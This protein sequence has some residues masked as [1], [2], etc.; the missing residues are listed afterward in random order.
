MDSLKKYVV[1]LTAILVML[2]VVVCSC[3]QT[4][5]SDSQSGLPLSS[6]PASGYS[7]SGALQSVPPYSSDSS[8]AVSSSEV[9]PSLS[10]QSSESSTS[11]S[12]GL[13]HYFPPAGGAAAVSSTVSIPSV[14]SPNQSV[15]KPEQSDD[16]PTS[17]APTVPPQEDSQTPNAG[18][19]EDGEMR[20]VWI[21]YIELNFTGLNA[22]Q[23]KQ[24]LQEMFNSVKDMGFNTVIVHARS[25]GDAYYKSSYF[26]Y[27]SYITGTQGADPGWDP[28]EYMVELAH[29]LGLKIQA[30]INPYR[31]SSA[32][33]DPMT[34]A[35]SNKARQWLTDSDP[36][37]DDWAIRCNGGIYFNPA[38][39]EVRRLII[40]GIREIVQNYDVDGVHFDDYFYPTTD[41]GFDAA[42]YSEYASSGG[43]LSLADWRR[44]QVNTLVSGVYQAVKSIDEDIPFGI[45]PAGNISN[46]YNSMYADV[47][48]WMS[49]KGYIDY[50]C[51]QLYWG[52][53]Y[54]NEQ[55]R[56]NNI[57]DTWSS[58]DMHDGLKLYF[59]LAVYKSGTTDAGSDEWIRNNDII[60]RQIE[61]SRTKSNCSGVILFSYSYVVSNV[62][63]CANERENY[64]LLF[65]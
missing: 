56:F 53:E 42:A 15:S 14:P 51:P 22:E 62:E 65:N 46:C 13:P 30:W 9:Q 34:L 36:S 39:P 37:N 31:V 48:L 57:A 17:Q 54:P 12:S 32:S 55:F 29:G 47:E 49:R 11:A 7:S 43:G 61:Y 18:A 2:T 16:A 35:E 27:S 25:H 45:S 58:L 21:S 59:G 33:D 4:A 8:D 26:P 64:L 19:D 28:L 63:S 40:D 23:S 5:G 44:A 10:V 38:I 60:K 1:I 41:A 20:A 52:F 24:K 50:I 6:A 3:S